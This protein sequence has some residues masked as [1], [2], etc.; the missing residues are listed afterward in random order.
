MI[1]KPIT[2]KL[3]KSSLSLVFL[4]LLFLGEIHLCHG[5]GSGLVEFRPVRM[6]CNFW[7]EIKSSQ[8]ALLGGMT[9]CFEFVQLRMW[10]VFT[11]LLVRSFAR[12]FRFVDCSSPRFVSFHAA[13][14]GWERGKH[15]W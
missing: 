13:R 6:G 8:F 4:P 1:I 2:M 15:I 11:R 7:K 10:C 3:F 12:L 9:S 14:L 5:R